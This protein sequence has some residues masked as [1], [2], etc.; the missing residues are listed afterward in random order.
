[1]AQIALLANTMQNVL[2][3]DVHR[4]RAAVWFSIQSRGQASVPRDFRLHDLPD[5]VKNLAFCRAAKSAIRLIP[6][7]HPEQHIV[8]QRDGVEGPAGNEGSVSGLYF[9]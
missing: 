7:T 9:G 5:R 4:Y 6:L 1:M 8:V 2:L 3:S